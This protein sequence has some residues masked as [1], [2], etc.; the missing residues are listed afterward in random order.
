[1]EEKR[2]EVN[3]TEVGE[4]KPQID[5]A[6]DNQTEE[7]HEQLKSKKVTRVKKSDL[8][9]ALNDLAKAVAEK[10]DYLGA[11]QRE[12]ADFDNYKK[13][14]SVAVSKA[15][16]DGKT[17]AVIALLPVLDNLERAMNAECSDK[18]FKD[19]IALVYKQLV[20]SFKSM[21]ITEIAS[22]GK[23]FDPNFHNAV[24]QVPAEEGEQS[25]IVKQVLMKGYLLGDR[26]VRHAMVQVTE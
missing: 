3:T 4:E 9:K 25:G 14:N 12:R 7:S 24:M 1:M 22:L 8:E 11:L 15:F 6:V 10:E 26:V 19:G 5:P 17:D 20:D 23:P 13:R 2:Q 18:A 21:G 16:S